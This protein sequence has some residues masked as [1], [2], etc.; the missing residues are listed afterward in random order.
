MATRTRSRASSAF[1][2]AAYE[3][4]VEEFLAATEDE[5][6]RNL[7]GLSDESALA[8]IYDRYEALFGAAT[9]DALRTAV[10]AGGEDERRNRGLLAFATDGFLNRAA[11]DLTDAVATAESRAVVIWR[12]EP[13]R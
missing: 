2:R 1:D 13:V 7:A 11:A 5:Q 6:Y 10:E 4:E 12:G 9:I 3:Q 8:P